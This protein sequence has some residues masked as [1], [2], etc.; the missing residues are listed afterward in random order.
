MSKLTTSSPSQ[1]CKVCENIS[2]NCRHGDD[3]SLCMTFADT[4]VGETINGYKALKLSKCG[5]WVVFKLDNSQEW[6]DE[7]R[8]KWRLERERRK[9]HQKLETDLRQ[10]QSLSADERDKEYRKLFDEL[11]VNEE[12]KKE[13]RRR[14]LTNSEIELAGYKS[15]DRYQKLREKYSNLLPGISSGGNMIMTDA[16]WLCPVRDKHGRIVAA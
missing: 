6:S 8:E 9:Q 3:I 15:I 1:P 14:G 16:G 10:K 5:M 4:K 12:D 7:Q 13:W 2:H 11:E